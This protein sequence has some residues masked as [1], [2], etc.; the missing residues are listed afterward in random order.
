MIAQIFQSEKIHFS[1]VKRPRFTE[2]R[3]LVE[4]KN[5]SENFFLKSQ[6]YKTRTVYVG[7]F[8]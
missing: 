3:K 1:I 6:L 5:R 4:Y 8:V 7:K 2:R